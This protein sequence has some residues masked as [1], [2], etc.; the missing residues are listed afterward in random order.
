MEENSKFVNNLMS[1]ISV[2]LLTIGLLTTDS[3]QAFTLKQCNAVASELN[4]L[5]PH[6]IDSI[7]T[8]Q[9]SVCLGNNPIYLQYRISLDTTKSN[10]STIQLA[11]LRTHQLNSWCTEPKLA[12]LLEVVA[13][14][15]VY[16]DKDGLY[17]GQTS[18]SEK[19][20][21]SKAISFDGSEYR[22][23]KDALDKFGFD[24]S[25]ESITK[26]GN[27]SVHLGFSEKEKVFFFRRYVMTDHHY[28]SANE[29]TKDAIKIKYRVEKLIP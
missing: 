25:T 23:I 26:F 2:G 24:G 21:S 8:A 6:R 29:A 15:Y 12:K 1:I 17:V 9:S 16:V 18:F 11:S 22:K 13:V 28:V 27:S 5:L 14:R 20:C 3:V 19:E 10:F 4:K 7:S